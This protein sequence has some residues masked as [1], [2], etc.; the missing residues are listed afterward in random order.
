MTTLPLEKVLELQCSIMGMNLSELRKKSC[1]LSMSDIDDKARKF[2]NRAIDLR[3]AQ[4]CGINTSGVM[5]EMGDCNFD[6]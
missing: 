5:V 2:I 6:V 3:Y 4:L 1:D